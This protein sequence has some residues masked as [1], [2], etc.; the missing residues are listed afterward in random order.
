MRLFDTHAHLNDPELYGR[1]D[2]VLARAQEAGVGHIVVPGYDYDSC[3]RALDLAER[4]DCISAAVGFHPNDAQSVQDGHLSELESW[5][6]LTTVVAVGEIGLDYHYDTPRDLQQ[7][8]LQEQV[9][10]AKRVNKPVVIHDRDAH[11]DIIRLLYDGGVQEVGGIMHCFSG[12]VEMMRT[13]LKLGLWISLGGPVTFKNAKKPVEVAGEVP[14]D[15]LLIETDSPWL[16]PHPLR[17]KQNEPALVRLIAEAIAEIRGLSISELAT[18]T[19]ANACR[20]FGLPPLL[21]ESHV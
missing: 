7:R 19:S 2:E 16:A 9:A 14:A 4:Y 17:G 3:L 8:L 13:C 11:E 1:V 12:S 10:M 20:L 15:R 21:E 6:Q 18:L 5:C